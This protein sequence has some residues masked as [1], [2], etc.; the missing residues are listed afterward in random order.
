MKRSGPRKSDRPALSARRAAGAGAAHPG[1]AY[2]RASDPRD[3]LQHPAPIRI[4]IADDHPVVRDG[5]CK[6]L[7]DEPG[8]EVV[9]QASDGLE[10]LAL[11]R[12]LDPD[13]L[14]LD[15]RMP[16]LSGLEVLRELART[17]TRCRV[18]LIAA[19]S[20]GT[21]FSKRCSS[22]PGASC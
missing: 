12:R 13:I 2:T 9:G 16:Q 8:L 7:Q 18:I 11:V 1:A 15:L 10:A 3:P 20:S 22:A 19:S 21:S 14:M 5:F 4:L 6:L 17:P